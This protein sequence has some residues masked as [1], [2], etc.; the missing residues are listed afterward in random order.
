MSERLEWEA[1]ERIVVLTGAGVSV[2]SGVRPFRGP[3][4][5][6]EEAWAVEAADV[7]TFE[8]DPD[9]VWRLFGPLRAQLEA[10]DPNPAHRALAELE[11]RLAPH[12]SL[13]LITQN[14]DSLHQRAGSQD[15]VEVHGT[16]ART[17]CHRCGADPYAD[18]A[19]HQQAPV[20]R[21][22]G[23]P[24]RPDVVLFGEML[25]PAVLWRVRNALNVCDLFVAAGTSGTVLPAAQ[26]VRSARYA[27][28]RTVLVNLEPME[29]R[30]PDFQEEILG[31]AEEV[32]PSLFGV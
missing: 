18:A 21:A 31:P 22:C 30:H 17:R 8:R 13:T 7:E 29:P 11:R 16:L 32:L 27:G 25:E 1:Y 28:A 14:V 26:F 24:E 19:P 3:G 15:V 9:V 12:Q 23:A 5:L 4:G 10:T 2:A 20:C 6:W